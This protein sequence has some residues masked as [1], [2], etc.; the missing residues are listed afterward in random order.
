MGITQLEQPQINDETTIWFDEK[1]AYVWNGSAFD[2]FIPG[3]TW[4]STDSDFFYAFNYR[5]AAP[6]DRLLFVTNFVSNAA[7]PMRY[8]DGITWTN[9][10]PLVTAANTLFSCRILVSYY[11]RLLA[12]NC[13][14]GLTAA[15]PGGAVNIS[16]RCRF[17]QLGSP[18]DVDAFRTD[19]FG[20]GGLIDAPTSEQIVGARS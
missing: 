16:N 19:I 14:E 15:G 20:R 11:G 10:A 7:N 8:T 2:E 5:G 18:I 17:S 9:F 4:A 3:T 13:W 12:L 1:Y 6:Q